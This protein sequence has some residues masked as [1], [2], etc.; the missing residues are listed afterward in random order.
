[1]QGASAADVIAWWHLL[2]R[3]TMN[4]GF[5]FPKDSHGSSVAPTSGAEKAAP[6]DLLKVLQ[7]QKQQR[8]KLARDPVYLAYHA[9]EK[10]RMAKLKKKGWSEP[11][12][13]QVDEDID[14]EARQR[15]IGLVSTA[16]RHRNQQAGVWA[17]FGK[18]YQ[19]LGAVQTV[20]TVTA[21]HGCALPQASKLHV[22]AAADKGYRLASRAEIDHTSP[23]P[24]WKGEANDSRRQKHRLP[25]AHMEEPAARGECAGRRRGHA[26]S[27]QRQD[28]RTHR[29][30]SM[31][32]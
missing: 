8:L 11:P 28:S 24:A 30:R 22:A 6:S 15:V 21:L 14:A 9:A 1:M 32:P 25:L 20:R 27:A 31:L 23:W 3:S 5:H 4:T 12:K 16:A 13:P 17:P 2:W 19:A 18:P 29:R 26:T 10:H 7:Q